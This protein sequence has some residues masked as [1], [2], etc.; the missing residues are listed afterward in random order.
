M[1]FLIASVKNKALK[2][3]LA[4]VDVKWYEFHVGVK[5]DFFFMLFMSWVGLGWVE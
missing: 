1:V 4:F 5:W 3:T 2:L